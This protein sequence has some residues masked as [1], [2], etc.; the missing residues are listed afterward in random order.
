MIVDH[1]EPYR[2][3]ITKNKIDVIHLIDRAEQN[4]APYLLTKIRYFFWWLMGGSKHAQAK[5]VTFFR[6]ELERAREKNMD[7]QAKIRRHIA[8]L[9][10]EMAEITKQISG[11]NDDELEKM[12]ITT[13]L[14]KHINTLK[15]LYEKLDKEYNTVSAKEEQN[16]KEREEDKAKKAKEKIAKEEDKEK[17]R[18]AKEEGKR[19]YITEYQNPL[20]NPS[21]GNMA[22]PLQA[23][24]T[25][26]KQ[27]KSF[28]VQEAEQLVVIAQQSPK[29]YRIF[30]NH[31]MNIL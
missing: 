27:Q 16:T 8:E 22:I 6:D 31:F 18:I 4:R 12:E 11:L 28:P 24:V 21:A 13:Q 25:I 15:N 1:T 5:L 29:D 10:A 23:F 19:E 9:Q 14:E 3:G 7:Y 2:K 30:E 17:R 20:F 26:V